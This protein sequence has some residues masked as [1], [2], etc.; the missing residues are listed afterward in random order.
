MIL[1]SA[2]YNIT[3]YKFVL[4][5]PMKGNSADWSY[6]NKLGVWL[7]KNEKVLNKKSPTDVLKFVSEEFPDL[8]EIDVR[9]YKC[10]GAKWVK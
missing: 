10:V 1:S 8:T 2:F 9:D 5:W 3:N 7:Q 6:S 4:Y